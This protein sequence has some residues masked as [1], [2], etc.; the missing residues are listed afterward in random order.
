MKEGKASG[1]RGMYSTKGNPMAPAKHV[2]EGVGPGSNPVQGK[3]NKM[4]KA[5]YNEKEYMRGKSGT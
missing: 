2:K 1:V 3:I 4:M 5:A